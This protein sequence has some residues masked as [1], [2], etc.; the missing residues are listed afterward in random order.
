MSEPDGEDAHGAALLLEVADAIGVRPPDTV[1][2]TCEK[3]RW[4]RP[5]HNLS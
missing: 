3:P 5:A 4:S 1:I 2:V